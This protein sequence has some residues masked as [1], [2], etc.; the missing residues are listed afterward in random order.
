MKN[1]EEPPFHIALLQPEIPGNTGNVGRLAVG[2][3][4]RLHLIAPLGFDLSEKAVRRAGI[5]HW[6]KVDLETHSS[7]KEFM[8]WVGERKL[9][10]FSAQGQQSYADLSVD[11]GDVLLF[12]PESSGLDPHFVKEHGA[13]RIPLPGDV[14]SLNLSNA[15]SVAAYHALRCVSPQ[16]F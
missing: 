7:F 8:D 6:S 16:H 13:W 10:A 15:V 4:V 2:L 3:G 11:P 14:R 1:R 9:C 5:D 12:G